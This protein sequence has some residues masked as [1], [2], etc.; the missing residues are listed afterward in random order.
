MKPL[1]FSI[2]ISSL[3]LGHT[4]TVTLPSWFLSTF[5]SKGL[6]QKY[7]LEQFLKPIFLQA[8]FNGDASQDI[9][10]IV[11]EKSTK[12]K[13]ILLIHGKTND[14]YFFGAGTKF[15][16]G[17]DDFMWADKWALYKKKTASETQ[18]DKITGDIL[19]TKE[20]KLTHPAILIEDFEDGAAIAGGIIYWSGKKYSW[21]HQGE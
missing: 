12:K 20:I 9:A 2:F 6:D 11:I 17:G 5:K 16:N 8:D 3:L 7:E 18:F 14:S 1:L 21:I 10:V 15:G 4:Q 19:G 13:G